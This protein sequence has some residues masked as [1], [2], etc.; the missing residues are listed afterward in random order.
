MIRYPVTLRVDHWIILTSGRLYL[1]SWDI[2]ITQTTMRRVRF[3][4]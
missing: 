2:Y 4:P 3:W 1:A